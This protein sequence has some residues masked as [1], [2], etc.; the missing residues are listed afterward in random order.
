MADKKEEVKMKNLTDEDIARI[1]RK[2]NQLDDKQIKEIHKIYD[3]FSQSI[4]GLIT[5]VRTYITEEDEIVEIDRL[6]RIVGF[7]SADER[8]LRCSEKIWSVRNYIINKDLKYFLDTDV[9]YAIKKDSK[10][11]M[12]ETLIEIV[13]D[14]FPT[15]SKEQQDIYWNKCV[16]LLHCVAQFKKLTGEI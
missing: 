7:L 16:I 11:R 4:N 3:K 15:L 2:L 12:I 6:K 13:K 10:Q 9:S 5:T 14:K 1:V 8:F